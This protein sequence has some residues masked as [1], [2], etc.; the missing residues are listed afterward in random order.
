MQQSFDEC[1]SGCNEH[2]RETGAFRKG[3]ERVMNTSAM[4]S[5]APG[6]TYPPSGY[7]S[8]LIYG[9]TTQYWGDGFGLN[10]RKS[11]DEMRSILAELKANRWIDKRTRAIFLEALLY[12]GNLDL[13]TSLTMVF[14]FS[15]TAGVFTH[16]RVQ[17]FRFHQWPG[18]IGYIY[19]LLEIT[20]VIVLTLTLT[21][22]GKR[23]KLHVQAAW[24]T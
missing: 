5:E 13:F 22:Y 9:L 24:P 21:H 10:L 12:N 8:L 17:D 2:A 4:E 20:Y 6:W 23:R 15:E 11:A 19:V 16:H 14:E 3:W 1:S 7:T 18:T